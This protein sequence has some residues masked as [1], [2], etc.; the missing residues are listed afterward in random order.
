MDRGDAAAARP[1]A[2]VAR[3]RGGGRSRRGLAQVLFNA[4]HDRVW[5]RPPLCSFS[6]DTKAT[7]ARR[8][9][10]T[11]RLLDPSMPQ[12]STATAVDYDAT[13]AWAV[14]KIGIGAGGSPFELKRIEPSSIA[15]DGLI[16]GGLDYIRFVIAQATHLLLRSADADGSRRRRGGDVDRQR[17]IRG[18]IAA[19]PRRGGVAAARVR[20]FRES[21]ADRTPLRRPTSGAGGGD[22][23]SGWR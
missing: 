5:N 13:L 18:R 22:A 21:S 4:A 3:G 20:P 23:R 10:T 15:D 19:T 6:N 12:P 8:D 7:Q 17:I 11:A 16:I 2:G 9:S 1:G 14:G